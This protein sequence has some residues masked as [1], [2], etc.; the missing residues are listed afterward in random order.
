MSIEDSLLPPPT[1]RWAL[2]KY[3]LGLWALR[4]WCAQEKH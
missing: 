4:R 2:L 3:K 1:K